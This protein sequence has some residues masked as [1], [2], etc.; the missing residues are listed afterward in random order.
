MDYAAYASECEYERQFGFFVRTNER[1]EYF[2]TREAALLFIDLH[3]SPKRSGNRER[4]V[5]S[6]V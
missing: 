6:N 1:T 3:C 2:T 4:L 5:A